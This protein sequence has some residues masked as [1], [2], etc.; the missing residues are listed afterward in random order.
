MCGFEYFEWD[1][2]FLIKMDN[3]H[4]ITDAVQ[5]GLQLIVPA[6]VQQ[7]STRQTRL[8]TELWNDSFHAVLAFCF[9]NFIASTV[10]MAA[11][12]ASLHI[13]GVR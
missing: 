11:N 5:K 9:K 6:S 13:N 8:R 2:Y 10:K 4:Q 12:K 1:L 3:I 7:G